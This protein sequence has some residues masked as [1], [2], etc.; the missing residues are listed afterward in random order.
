M[1][2]ST[3]PKYK[4]SRSPRLPCSLMLED[5]E[6]CHHYII[7][8]CEQQNQLTFAGSERGPF[9]FVSQPTKL[10]SSSFSKDC[11]WFLEGCQRMYDIIS[12]FEL[13]PRFAPLCMTAGLSSLPPDLDC[14][15]Q[16]LWMST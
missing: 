16:C 1:V 11:D 12:Q 14:V 9:S 6:V 7:T 10:N 15:K 8:G 3:S 13:L 2:G 4:F 5:G